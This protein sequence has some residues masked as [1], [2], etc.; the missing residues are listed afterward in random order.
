VFFGQR[1]LYLDEVCPFYKELKLIMAHGADPWWGEAIRLLLKY[2][3]PLH[4]DLGLF[5]E[6]LPS[7]LIHFM[8]TRSAHKI[9]FISDHPSLAFE[10]CLNEAAAL[11]PR[12]GVLTKYLRE[13]AL[14]LF[15]WN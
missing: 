5:A 9:L 15:R 14:T 11:P 2:P 8:S 12:E 13:S 1:P 6:D 4:D 3:K 10:R 7:E